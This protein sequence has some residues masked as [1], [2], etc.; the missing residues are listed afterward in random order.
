M[1]NPPIK[2]LEKTVEALEGVAFFRNFAKLTFNRHVNSVYH[3][4]SDSH[5]EAKR[6]LL[7]TDKDTQISIANKQLLFFFSLQ[8]FTQQTEETQYLTSGTVPGD[9][10][11]IYL[12]V[13]LS[14]SLLYLPNGQSVGK[15]YIQVPHIDESK[16]GNL[17]DFKFTHGAVSRLY[18]FADR[19]QLKVKA[20]DEKEADRAI[21]ELLKLVLDKWKLGNSENHSFTG[22]PPRD[23]T[24]PKLLGITSVCNELHVHYPHQRALTL[25]V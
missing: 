1:A 4:N 8:K 19:K 3:Q 22:K 17:K 18:V 5:I 14:P 7:I 11:M 2:D 21:N 24:A 25:F 16:L 13:Q 10:E 6:A 23:K 20:I 12:K 15:R 9:P